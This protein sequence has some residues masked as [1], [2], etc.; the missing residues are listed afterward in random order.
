M[1]PDFLKFILI[2]PILCCI[3]LL[4]ESFFQKIIFFKLFPFYI[5]AS[6][7]LIFKKRRNSAVLISIF[8]SVILDFF[9]FIYPFG[10]ISVC[11]FLSLMATKKASEMISNSGPLAFLLLF[12]FCSVLY[13]GFFFL[14]R[15][16]A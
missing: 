8:S 11:L 12:L 15:L 4:Q 16:L 9:S 13:N 14:G 6:F 3:A 10:I 5:L 1:K 2:I 7:F